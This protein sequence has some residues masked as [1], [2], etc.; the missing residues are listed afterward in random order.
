[1]RL[2]LVRHG[3][4]S[5][6]VERRLDTRE[7]GPGLTPLGRRQAAA[8]VQALAH[9]SVD[10]IYTSALL[11]TQETAAP[12]A[13]A[14]ARESQVRPGLGE[15][16]AGDLEMRCDDEAIDLY[17]GTVFAWS[18]GDVE[19]HMPGGTDGRTALSRFDAVVEEA[20][21]TGAGTVAMVSHGAAIR[22]WVAARARNAGVGFVSRHELANTG[23]VVLSGDPDRGWQVL[24]WQ[25]QAPGR[26]TDG[27]S[28][29]A[30]APAERR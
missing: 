30:G 11:R 17:L 9:E 10:A 23:V 24:S 13:E 4:T 18:A 25:E 14:T 16:S 6:N 7:P 20:A 26:G 19:R 8:L 15:I 29:P 21:G 3:Q 12:L 27:S 22:M 2:L 5:S 1:M 28:G